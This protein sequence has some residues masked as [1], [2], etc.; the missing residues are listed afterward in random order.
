MATKLRAS[1]SVDGSVYGKQQAHSYGVSNTAQKV[2]D[3][4]FTV[5]NA[6]ALN[7]L[8]TID[9]AGSKVWNK[10]NQIV[11]SNKGS[12]TAEIQ[13]LV[14]A[15][16]AS[17]DAVR[18][19]DPYNS[20]IVMLLKPGDFTVL[21]SSRL[22]LYHANTGNADPWD[23][24]SAPQSSGNKYTRSFT[25]PV[26]TG[27][28]Q[29]FA[30][31]IDSVTDTQ[32][33]GGTMGSGS[34]ILST[35]A[36]T[37][38]AFKKYDLLKIEDEI[39]QITSVNS[40]TEATIVRAMFGTSA[41]SHSG[42]TNVSL[43]F[44]KDDT[45]VMT[46]D[47]GEY[48]ASSF[49]GYGRSVVSG[50]N[51][52][53]IVPGSVAIKFYSNPFVRTQLF[54]VS[55]NTNSQL[56]ASTAYTFKLT[57]NGSAS[58]LM[59]ITTDAKVLTLGT[60]SSAGKGILDKMQAQIDANNLDVS[61]SISGGDIIYTTRSAK[62]DGALAVT[63]PGSGTALF[64]SGVF[65]AVGSHSATAAQIPGDEDLSA[66]LMDDGRGNLSRQ[67]GGSGVINYET[68]ACKFTGCP[69]NANFEVALS[70]N[71][72]LS[73]YETGTRDNSI[74]TIYARSTNQYRDAKIH[75]LL[76]DDNFTDNTIEFIAGEP[77]EQGGFAQDTNPLRGEKVGRPRSLR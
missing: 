69:A 38:N 6:D 54:D 58:S 5:D 36:N 23:A 77:D 28:T 51:P 15:F 12:Q 60:G 59:T 14:R 3:T 64:G 63:A 74:A 45:T 57:V 20:K 43:Y 25:A 33:D 31:A 55:S 71:S 48:Y 30:G 68:G 29:P 27:I 13:I 18:G 16:D 42:T 2:F 24:S 35:P 65:P 1:L 61:V 56:A 17:D 66:L 52:S 49:F 73:G 7:E 32:L 26:T 19:S 62:S 67:L 8:V 53:G 75:V 37:N 10:A 41:V 70:Y 22:F 76:L 46:N 44:L 39:V 9:P 34:L 50:T 72:S 21:P 11:L 4:T 40:S 47:G